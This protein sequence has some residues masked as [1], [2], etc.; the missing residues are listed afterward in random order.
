MLES[1]KLGT[2]A[3]ITASLLIQPPQQDV[4]SLCSSL[5]STWFRA[6]IQVGWGCIGR[7]GAALTGPPC[8]SSVG[9]ALWPH[10]ATLSP[11]GMHSQGG[12][13]QDSS[14]VGFT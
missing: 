9:V 5:N 3:T 11:L 1:A 7:T 10:P 13:G 4:Q 2:A 12:G 8:P 6:E 14:Q